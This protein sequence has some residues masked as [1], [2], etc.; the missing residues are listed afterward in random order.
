MGTKNLNGSR[1]QNPPISVTVWAETSYDQPACQICSFYVHP[2]TRHE[3]RLKMQKLGWFRQSW[4]TQGYPQL[5]RH[6]HRFQYKHYDEYCNFHIVIVLHGI[7]KVQWTHCIALNSQ[8]VHYAYEFPFNFNKNYVSIL[9]LFQ[10]IARF[11]SKVAN[12]N[13]TT[14]SAFGAPIGGDP[15]WNVPLFS[16]SQNYSPW[17]IAWYY[18]HDPT[19]SSFDAIL[20]CIR[21][22]NTWQWHILR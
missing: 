20:E 5:W 16:A 7:I 3:K 15:I 17:A 13:L 18:L 2:L 11:S 12:F 6:W 19:F 10:V 4:I 8:R 14:P 22:T 1:D 21:Q 9:Y